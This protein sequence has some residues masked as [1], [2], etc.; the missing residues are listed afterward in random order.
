M[1]GV[2]S[3]TGAAIEGIE[4]ITG[5]IKEVGVIVA[6]IAMAIGEQAIVTRDVAG[7]IT[8]ASI[9]VKARRKPQDGA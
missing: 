9:G 3:S 4:S 1:D 6:S 5:V 8:S 2:Q 7:N